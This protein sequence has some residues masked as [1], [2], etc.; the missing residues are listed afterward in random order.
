MKPFPATLQTAYANL[1]DMHVQRPAFDFV[2]APFKVTRSG[3][4]YWYATE[5]PPGGGSPRQRYIGP[6]SET[7]RA[8]IEQ[9]AIAGQNLSR[10]REAASD[11][12]AMLRAGGAPTLDRRTGS[13]LRAMAD[14]GAFRLG[15]TLVGTYAF[16][17]YDPI[18]G[19]RLA[20]PSSSI[21]QTDD[22]DI[23]SFERLSSDIGDSVEPD[24]PD[25]L[26]RL[27]FSPN[28]SL[29]PN[30]P[31]KWVEAD[32]TFRLDFLTP[33]FNDS[34]EPRR[35]EALKVWAHPF[36]FLN[37]LIKDPI[38]AV[39]LY[40]EG[41]LI[42]VPR[43][44]RFAVHKLIVSQRRDPQGLPKRGKDIAQARTLLWAMS[45]LQPHEV[46]VAIEEADQMGPSWST[47]LDQALKIRFRTDRAVTHPNRDAV[48]YRGSALGA[49][50]DLGVSGTVQAMVDNGG[51][52]RE[53][54]EAAIQRKFRREPAPDLMLTS[55]DL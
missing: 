52:D 55:Y 32:G 33:S 17:H 24:L 42:Q 30:A 31:T 44:E 41:V 36:H 27:G 29:Y 48:V 20:D 45:G 40:M 18:L 15:A 28:P 10:F 11:L 38:P 19:V 34:D 26:V 49:E 35:L 25:T 3:R 46:R 7:T 16:R 50:L 23:A 37:Y 6:D 13:I 1:L 9:M 43:P 5:R 14:S 2:G 21:T 8:R 53:A 39:S 47:A 22:L 54:L 51:L 12:V 4:E